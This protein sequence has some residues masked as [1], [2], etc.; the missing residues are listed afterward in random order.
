MKDTLCVAFLSPKMLILF[1]CVPVEDRHIR[2]LYIL[3]YWVLL[4]LIYTNLKHCLMVISCDWPEGDYFTESSEHLRYFVTGFHRYFLLQGSI[5]WEDQ[6][7]CVDGRSL[8]YW[9]VS[10]NNHFI[11]TFCVMKEGHAGICKHFSWVKEQK[12]R[13]IGR[14]TRERATF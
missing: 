12:H 3:I 2:H 5:A 1:F 4:F 8:H 14:W 9:E 10:L 6:Q 7:Q 13:F 11:E